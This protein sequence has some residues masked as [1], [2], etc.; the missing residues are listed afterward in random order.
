M[1]FDI[2]HLRHQSSRTR[3]LHFKEVENSN[4]GHQEGFRHIKYR[5][6]LELRL[7]VFLLYQLPSIRQFRIEAN[8]FAN[9]EK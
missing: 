9:P 2:L 1:H 4:E 6:I 7:M 5:N 8:T 3:S